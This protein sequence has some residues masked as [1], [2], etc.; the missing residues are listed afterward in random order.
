MKFARLFPIVPDFSKKIFVKTAGR[1]V[2]GLSLVPPKY[3]AVSVYNNHSITPGGFSGTVEGSLY[4]K[5]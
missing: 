5:L 3:D 1:W 4:V 2:G